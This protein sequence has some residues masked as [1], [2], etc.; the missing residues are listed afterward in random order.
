MSCLE[1]EKCTCKTCQNKFTCLQYSNIPT[2]INIP[3]LLLSY[4]IPSVGWLC[5]FRLPGFKFNRV[6]WLTKTQRPGSCH[7][8]TWVNSEEDGTD[9]PTFTVS[10]GCPTKTPAAPEKQETGLKITYEYT[11]YDDKTNHL[12]IIKRQS[13]HI[14]QPA[15]PRRSKII[16]WS[17][18]CTLWR[19]LD[20]ALSCPVLDRAE[21]PLY[22]G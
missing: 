15:P 16:S 1:L 5:N 21:N 3:F 20:S 9:A 6:V 13:F 18:H 7:C 14:K 19:K 22:N 4:L 2:V 8:L 12:L 17:L 10:N 11:I